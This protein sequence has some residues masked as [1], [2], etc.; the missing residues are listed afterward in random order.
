MLFIFL[1]K[2]KYPSI[3]INGIGYS[4]RRQQELEEGI[5]M[6]RK[7][8]YIK[9]YQGKRIYCI[10]WSNPE[11]TEP[12]AVIQIAHGMAEHIDRYDDFAGFLVQ[13]GYVVFGNDH[14]GHGKTLDKDQVYGHLSDEKGWQK[15][16]RDL[17]YLREEIE[18]QYP[19]KPVIMLGHSMGS[20]LARDYA[21]EFGSHLQ[22]L[23]LSGTGGKLGVIGNLGLWIAKLEKLLRGK[24]RKS[25]LL[26]QLIFGK[27]NKNFEPAETSFD[28]LSSN[29][30]EVRAYVEDPL[31]GNIMTAG[32][33]VDLLQGIKK[34][35][36][37]KNIKKMPKDLPVLLFSG[38]LDPVGKEGK[39]VREVQK[40]IEEQGVRDLQVVLYPEGRHEMLHENNKEAV[41]Q[42]ILS[43]LEEKVG[44][45]SVKRLEGESL[46]EV[47]K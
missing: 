35:H 46:K 47:V 8:Y 38:E 45:P 14:R 27:Y 25:P 6:D 39:G 37:P 17:N 22:G 44:E 36:Q 19:E 32:F 28:W 20:F 33:Y 4:N 30:W 9:G 2:N 11:N 41:Y 34:I 7:G 5:H 12:K 16:L 15:T 29:E 21:Q 1:F 24:R 10:R 3:E 26:D 42:D 13:K 40:G 18:K 43:W 31:C 23:I